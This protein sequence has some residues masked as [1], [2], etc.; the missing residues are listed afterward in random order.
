MFI[1]QLSHLGFV[2]VFISCFNNLLI[3]NLSFVLN[4]EIK[5]RKF[6][7]KLQIVIS[8]ENIF[9]PFFLYELRNNKW[10]RTQK[11]NGITSFNRFEAHKIPIKWIS[12]SFYTHV[13][14]FFWVGVNLENGRMILLGSKQWTITTKDIIFGIFTLPC[15]YLSCFLLLDKFHW[16]ENIIKLKK[17]YIGTRCSFFL[18]SRGVQN[19]KTVTNNLKRLQLLYSRWKIN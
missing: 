10:L 14:R 11:Q 16:I 2:K 12:F 8:M 3:P 19:M 9:I 15:W 18:I 4:V 13:E 17:I 6:S 5:H 7:I 1:N